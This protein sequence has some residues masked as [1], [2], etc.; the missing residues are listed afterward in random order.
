M[1]KK[2]RR[3]TAPA[4]EKYSYLQSKH[5]PLI[6]QT[7]ASTYLVGGWA[8][9]LKNMNVNWDDEIPNTWENEKNVA[10]SYHQPVV[11][12]GPIAFFQAGKWLVHITFITF[13]CTASDHP[14]KTSSQD[15]CL[16]S[17]RLFQKA[18]EKNS[19]GEWAKPLPH[20]ERAYSQ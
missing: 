19:S 13:T 11:D 17:L 1:S 6:V 9:P 15:L 4:H 5:F 12:Q 2:N 14:L 16:P 7:I 3:A 20:I 8:T 10:T 18:T